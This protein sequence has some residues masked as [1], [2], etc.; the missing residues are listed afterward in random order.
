MEEDSNSIVTP[1]QQAEAAQDL[2]ALS[3]FNR[4]QTMTYNEKIRLA[5]TGDTEARRILIRDPHREVQTSVLQNPRLTNS[6]IVAIAHARD[7][8]EAV[9]KQIAANREWNKL[10]PV[11]LALAKNPRTPLA[12]AIRLVPTL[13]SQDLKIIA[14][15]KAVPRAVAHA[16]RSKIHQHRYR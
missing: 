10:Y 3:L 16:A 12:V 1:R 15:S 7:V 11:R 14:R 5:V 4:I 8:N 6:E 9:L 13:F 2:G